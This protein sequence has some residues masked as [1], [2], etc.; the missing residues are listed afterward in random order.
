MPKKKTGQIFVRE[1]D[2]TNAVQ[3]HITG[4][5]MPNSVFMEILNHIKSFRDSRAIVFVVYDTKMLLLIREC[6]PS[7]YYERIEILSCDSP[8]WEGLQR[9]AG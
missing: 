8:G 2:G 9:A 3:I 5:L 7:E 1:L 6:I 4:G